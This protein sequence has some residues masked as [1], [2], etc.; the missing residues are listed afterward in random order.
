MY[1]FLSKNGQTV[2][3]LL[4]FAFVAIYLIMIATG[5]G[6]DFDSLPREKQ[7][8]TTVFNFGIIG[9][10]VLAVLALVLA[11]V[12][13]VVQ[14]VTNPKGSIK[15]LGV[16]GLIAVIFFIFR[17]MGAGDFQSAIGPTLEKFE[18]TEGVSSYISGAIGTAVALAVIAVIALAI[19]EIINFFK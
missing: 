5:L 12:F 15:V 1:K 3:F 7:F 13:G 10:V 19:S 2:G 9:A 16:L 17:G 8:E 6:G 14:F 11:V 4:G 18:I